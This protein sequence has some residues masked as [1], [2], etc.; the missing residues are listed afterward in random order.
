MFSPFFVPCSA[1]ELLTILVRSSKTSATEEMMMFWHGSF[2][3]LSF[4]FFV[5]FYWKHNVG[6]C[7]CV[8]GS[9]DVPFLLFFDFVF[10]RNIVSPLIEGSDNT[11]LLRVVYTSCTLPNSSNFLYMYCTVTGCKHL[12]IPLF[13]P[14]T[15]FI[16]S[17][18]NVQIKT[19]FELFKTQ[20][21]FG[22]SPSS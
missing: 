18:P 4:L 19:V 6:G 9:P 20:M 3:S 7:A 22:T 5:V 11:V 10:G 14:C 2:F 8:K 15:R 17:Q 13:D 12:K 21:R 16:I 1:S